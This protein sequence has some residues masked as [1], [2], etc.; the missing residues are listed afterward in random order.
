MI[1]TSIMVFQLK[2]YLMVENYYFSK[3]IQRAQKSWVILDRY[4]QISLSRLAMKTYHLYPKMPV[5]NHI[6]QYFYLENLSGFTLHS[7]LLFPFIQFPQTF[8]V[9]H[10]LWW[11]TDFIR[12]VFGWVS[13]EYSPHSCK[14]QVS[15]LGG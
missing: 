4:L 12:K 3:I 13:W 5:N 8:F 7:Y 15:I 10:I 6:I 9:E 14:L 11:F 2:S 1:I